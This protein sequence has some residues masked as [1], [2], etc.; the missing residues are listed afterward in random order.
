MYPQKEGGE[1]KWR[2][3]IRSTFHRHELRFRNP[4]SAHKKGCPATGANCVGVS[5]LN[6]KASTCCSSD[7][8]M[9]D[10]QQNQ[11]DPLEVARYE[12]KDSPDSNW[13]VQKFGGTSVGK[14]ALNII[15]QVVL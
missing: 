4:A 11:K 7:P 9:D 3:T 5:S 12:S 1:T 8:K 14:F 6:C 13:V 10:H 2:T 15:D